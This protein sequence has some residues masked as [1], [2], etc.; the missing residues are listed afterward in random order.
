MKGLKS[1][2]ALLVILIGLGAYIYYQGATPTDTTTKQEKVFPALLAS[3]IDELTVKSE[4]GDVTTLKK[5]DGTWNLVSP[6]AVAASDTDVST[7]TS[8]LA[9]IEI[10]RVVDENATDLKE[11]G[12]ETPRLSIDFKAD[13]GKTSGRL[14]LGERS[15]TGGNLYARR[16]DQKRV[17]LV[18][19]TQEAGFNK[20]S[21]ELRDKSVFK[22]DRAKVDGVE[23]NVDGKTGELTRTGSEW[24]MTKP[25]AARADT[26]VL[27]GLLGKLENAQMKS[28]VT[29]APSDADLKKFG[30]GTPQAT[31]TLRLGS[32]RATLFVGGKADDGSVYLRESSKPDVYAVDQSTADEFK[33][34]IEDYRRKEV[35]DFRAFNATRVELSR[36]G[37]TVVLERAKAKEEGQP[38]TWHRSAPSPGDPD[39]EKV[40]TM[41]AGLA[42]VRSTSFVAV[43][44]GLGLETPAL[45][46]VV[47]FDDGK[48]EE[49][50]TF[51]RKGT[52]AYASRTD[53]PGAAKIDASKLDDTL[54]VLDEIAK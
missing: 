20:S 45:V 6:I 4:A 1:T 34:A 7:I 9:D 24:S 33:K 46:V 47:K 25:V 31:V 30:F 27:D 54:K 5:T 12:L 23:L 48:K 53:D 16:E 10:V 37:Q 50:V 11:Y 2:L 18:S 40:E 29:A 52:D 13:G 32:A 44:S 21:F 14:L 36:G 49:R 39:R 35:F 51:G 41:L 22:F 28:V 43:T 8:G 26:S 3:A 17:F 15:A 19:Q 42:D 38:D